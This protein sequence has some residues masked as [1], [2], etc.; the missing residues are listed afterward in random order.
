MGSGLPSSSLIVRSY[1]RWGGNC[2]GTAS[3]GRKASEYFVYFSGIPELSNAME[4]F[5]Y[6]FVVKICDTEIDGT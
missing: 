5:V 3:G 1:S 4:D 2:D 6:S